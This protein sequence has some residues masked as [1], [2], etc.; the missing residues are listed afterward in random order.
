V[1]YYKMKAYIF[2]G[3]V[4]SP[5]D[6]E[7]YDQKFMETLETFRPISGREIKGQAPRKM[8]WI[9][10][11]EGTTIDSLAEELKLT[12]REAEDLRLI[13]NLYPVGEPKAGDWIKVFTRES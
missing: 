8:S 2:T 7:E 1:I 5:S 13:N 3:E 12:A 9:Q 6:F 4:E 10:A 11:E